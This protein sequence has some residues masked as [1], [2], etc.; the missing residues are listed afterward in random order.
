MGRPVNIYVI[1]D[2]QQKP[3]VKNPLVPVAFD[4]INTLPDYVVHIGDHFDFPSLGAYDKGK[5]SFNGNCYV[6]D[7]H[8]GNQAFYEFWSIIAMGRKDNPDWKCKFNFT[9]GN[10]EF[11]RDKALDTAPIEFIQ[12]LKDYRPDFTG[13]DV[14]APFLKPIIINGVHFVH[15][16]ANEFS[17]RAVSTAN[18]ALN[19]KHQS[20]VC[21]HKQALEYAEATTLSGKRIMGLI[22]GACYFHNEGYKGPQGNSHFRGTAYLRNV[23]DGQWEMEIRN[24]KTLERKYK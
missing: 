21:G 8:A 17:G 12:L 7:I 19:K 3:G 24:L 16:I 13:W 22:I 18:A 15:Y 6:K 2:T 9:N 11:R 20:F 5:H 10:H 14:V 4:I 23:L 1:G